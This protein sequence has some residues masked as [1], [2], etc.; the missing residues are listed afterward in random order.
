MTRRGPRVRLVVCAALAW[1]AAHRAPLLAAQTRPAP[2]PSAPT[3]PAIR[4]GT[5]VRPD[6]VAIGDPFTLRVTI[7]VPAAAT[8]EWPSITDTAAT[9]SMRA[10]PKVSIESRGDIRRETADYVLAAWNIGTLPIGLPDV[11]VRLTDGVTAIP[12]TDARIVVQTV[13]PADTSLHVPKPARGLFLRPVPWWELWWP[14]A[15]IALAFALL[16]WVLR[17]RRRRVVAVARPPV[18]VFVRA[19]HDFERL[20]RLALIDVG[21]RGRAVAL[22]V[23]VLRTYLAA[24]IPSA[25]LSLTSAELA[26]AVHDD[27]R[28]PHDRLATLLFDADQIKFA[29]ESITTAHA[30]KLQQDARALVESVEAADQAQRQAQREAAREAEARRADERR[31]EE[32]R[33]RRASRRPK[34][35]AK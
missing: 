10:A 31:A 6:T 5:V 29:H 9:V 18:D 34:A 32:D 25:V 16:W 1:H 33:A 28:V 21:E 13:L 35:G 20:H 23:E 2:P 22:A 30:G 11:S 12:L 15:A 24:R 27:R 14:V 4:A 19:M 7:E 3:A 8:I 17:R 26:Q